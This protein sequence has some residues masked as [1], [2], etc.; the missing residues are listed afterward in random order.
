MGSIRGTHNGI[1]CTNE[2]FLILPSF[3]SIDEQKL[4]AS[5]A[6]KAHRSHTKAANA[7]NNDSSNTKC[8]CF[9]EIVLDSNEPL[10]ASSSKSLNLGLKY[11]GS[12][13]TSLPAAVQ[14]SYRAFQTAAHVYG[15]RHP[16]YVSISN[17][18][19]NL[20]NSN[21]SKLTGIA[22]L[23]GPS[24]TMKPHYDSPTQPNQRE[25]WLIMFT[26][27]NDVLFQLNDRQLCLS[28]GDALVM[29]SMNVLHGVVSILPPK[30]EEVDPAVALGLS[31]GT[32]LGLLLWQASPPRL[33]INE[34][35]TSTNDETLNESD[36]FNPLLH[37]LFEAHE[38]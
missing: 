34:N 5:S 36:I 28:S 10:H 23:Y 35:K 17:T 12:P 31:P 1:S 9:D 32:R 18:L 2:R 24:A 20:A 27:G 3:L 25:E 22:L 4:L 15:Q 30:L 6:I 13:L 21:Q 11:C 16:Q 26:L 14:F 8:S 38:T 7:T 29:D 37:R 33:K 19:Q